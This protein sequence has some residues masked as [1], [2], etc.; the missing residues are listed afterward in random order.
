MPEKLRFGGALAVVLLLLFA[1]RFRAAMSWNNTVRKLKKQ[2]CFDS[3]HRHS[4]RRTCSLREFWL[5]CSDRSGQLGDD[6]GRRISRPPV[7]R[8]WVRAGIPGGVCRGK[9]VGTA[10]W[11]V[12]IAMQDSKRNACL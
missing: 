4:L 9:V 10:P 11:A 3:Y 1:A 5:T 7:P 6:G 8:V 12:P 2:N